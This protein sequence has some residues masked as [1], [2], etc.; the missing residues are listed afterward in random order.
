[1]MIM[2]DHLRRVLHRRWLI[3]C[4]GMSPAYADY[5]CRVHGW[6]RAVTADA[7]RREHPLIGRVLAIGAQRE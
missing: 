1:M 2:M 4:W 5:L 3:R 6:H 7:W